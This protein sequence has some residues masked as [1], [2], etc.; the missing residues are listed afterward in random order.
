MNLS[1]CQQTVHQFTTVDHTVFDRLLFSVAHHGNGLPFNQTFAAEELGVSKRS[2]GRTL[3]KLVDAGI[4]YRVSGGFKKASRFFLT[5]I[6]NHPLLRET[7]HRF[8]SV[9]PNFKINTRL[10][11][12]ILSVNMLLSGYVLYEDLEKDIP[13]PVR[14][15]YLE[16]VLIYVP[17]TKAYKKRAKVVNQDTVRKVLEIERAL[18]ARGERLEN[19][20]IEKVAGFPEEC[21]DASVLKMR[22]AKVKEPF[23]FFMHLCWKWC[24]ENNREPN[25]ATSDYLREHDILSKYRALAKTAGPGRFNRPQEKE[26]DNTSTIDI[27]KHKS[28]ERHINDQSKANLADYQRRMQQVPPV[29]KKKFTKDHPLM[30]LCIKV[31]IRMLSEMEDQWSLEALVIRRE[32]D[33]WGVDYKHVLKEGA[34]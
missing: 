24:T 17:R 25:F 8:Y 30:A 31:S 5:D 9:I 16:P 34:E 22:K 15:G 3:K 14:T 18:I 23:R 19:M 10:K 12:V 11:A 2:V 32:L 13:D 1:T 33:E 29:D 27:E 4:C 6:I 28:T 21:L 20:D 26:F 7:L